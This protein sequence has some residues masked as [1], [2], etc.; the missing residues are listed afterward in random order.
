V[1]Q[2]AREAR[3]IRWWRDGWA[4]STVVMA[5]RATVPDGLDPFNSSEV[6]GSTVACGDHKARLT[7]AAI[8]LEPWTFCDDRGVDALSRDAQYL[9]RTV[10]S[11]EPGRHV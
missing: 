6:Q 10:S 3:L 1:K 9:A 7:S 4:L 2:L 5:A 8:A 11:P